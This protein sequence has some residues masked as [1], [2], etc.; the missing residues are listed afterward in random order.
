[1]ARTW[2]RRG[3]LVGKHEIN[4]LLERHGR[5][6]KGNVKMQFREVGWGR[7]TG[8]AQDRDRLWAF[9]YKEAHL[10]V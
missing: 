10:W 5:R 8:L 7:G 6:W 2:V 4:R 3:A 1:M 9:L